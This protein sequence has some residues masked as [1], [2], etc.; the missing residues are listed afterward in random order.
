MLKLKRHWTVGSKIR[1]KRRQEAWV[2]LLSAFKQNKFTKPIVECVGEGSHEHFPV[3]S[4]QWVGIHF[5][6]IGGVQSV[7]TVSLLSG[8]SAL[9]VS[10][11]RLTT[12]SFGHSIPLLL[13]G[14]ILSPSVPTICACRGTT[15]GR[16]CTECDVFMV[17]GIC[18]VQYPVLEV[19]DHNLRK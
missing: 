2:W 15:R 11:P 1:H 12:G 3:S 7:L 14:K 6:P 9:P 5:L 16:N 19:S 17:E 4:V 18:G 13:R 8:L 10:E